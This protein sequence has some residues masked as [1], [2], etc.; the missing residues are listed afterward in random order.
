[1]IYYLFIILIAAVFYYLLLLKKDL[2]FGSKFLIFLLAFWVL[3]ICSL[4]PGILSILSPLSALAATVF[5]AVSGGYLIY[6]IAA[7]HKV[8]KSIPLLLLP[9]GTDTPQLLPA[10][11]NAL[12]LLPIGLNALQLL[13]IGT[14]DLQLLHVIINAPPLLPPPANLEPDPSEAVLSSVE[15]P[16]LD[17]LINAAFQAKEDNNIALAIELFQSALEYVED[18]SIKGMICTELVFLFRERGR[19]ADAAKLMEG[20]LAKNVSFLSPDLYSQFKRLV[21][22]LQKLNELLIE[23]EQPNLPFSQVPP[24]LKLSAE[25]ALKE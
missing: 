25:Q 1:V 8:L 13:P 10:G 17:E 6:S 2:F 24:H 9:A 20:F 3:V 21:S 19:Y 23:L 5:L 12:Q 11:T 14:D 18:S 7:H 15:E 22:Y 16:S 4:F